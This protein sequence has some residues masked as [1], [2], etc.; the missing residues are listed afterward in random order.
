MHDML[1]TLPV[2]AADRVLLAPCLACH[3]SN[4]FWR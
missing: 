4:Q 2:A 3:S 1:H